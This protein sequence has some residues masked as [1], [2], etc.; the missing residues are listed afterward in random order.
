M[1]NNKKIPIYAFSYSKRYYF[2][3]PWKWFKDL[4]IAVK[5]LHHRAYFG[6]CWSDLWNTDTYIGQLL[7]NML[8]ELAERSHGWPQSE[9]HPNFED[10]QLELRVL[11]KLL[12]ILNID[13]LLEQDKFEE[14]FN[15]YRAG[16][17]IYPL[18]NLTFYNEYVLTEDEC[19]RIDEAPTKYERL[20]IEDEIL[21]VKVFCR[22]GK[23]FRSLWD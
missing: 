10:W 8:E 20:A 15:E 9:E 12:N 13:V 16:V 5:N 21:R 23:I 7:P 18:R 22:L 19:K 1:K 2:T 4:W 6:W 3:H 14:A 17:P 11:A